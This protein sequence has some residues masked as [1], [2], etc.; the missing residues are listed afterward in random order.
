M[1]YAASP[2]HEGRYRGSWIPEADNCCAGWLSARRCCS[3]TFFAVVCGSR[4][5]PAGDII[6]LAC[7]IIGAFGGLI[8]GLVIVIRHKMAAQ[9]SGNEPNNIPPP[10]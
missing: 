6:L 5:L 9:Q 3:D 8:N 10:T 7:P 2:N 4:F 1:N